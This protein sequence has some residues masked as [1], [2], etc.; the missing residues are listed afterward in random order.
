MVPYI[1]R[2]SKTGVL[3]QNFG[4]NFKLV[5]ENPGNSKTKTQSFSIDMEAKFYQTNVH[6]LLTVR[7]YTKMNAKTD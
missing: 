1:N 7:S 5:R 4:Q 2:C 6:N 3:S